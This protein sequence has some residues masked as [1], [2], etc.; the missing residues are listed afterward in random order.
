M[1]GMNPEYFLRPVTEQDE[2]LLIRLY[3]TTR[4]DEVA[5]WGWSAEQQ[6]AFLRMQYHAQKRTYDLIYSD[7]VYSI[8]EADQGK[9]AGRLI[10]SYLDG[11]TVLTD[12]AL[13]P[14]WRNRGI[15]AAVIA[16]VLEK[17]GQDNRAVR[18]QVLKGN[19]A[20]RLYE[21]LGFVET[22]ESATHI[23]MKWSQSCVKNSEP[24]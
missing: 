22:G 2:E 8:I 13:L 21:R 18:L 11:D 3:A 4:A 14:E 7:S 1:N 19:P 23:N 16:G 10:L 12:I 20:A 17:A 9:P 5:A 24:D 15:G 6:D